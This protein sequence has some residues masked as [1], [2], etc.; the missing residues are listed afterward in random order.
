M[1]IHRR[2]FGTVLTMTRSRFMISSMDSRHQLLFSFL[3]ILK[4][5]HHFRK[6]WKE[7]QRMNRK[8]GKIVQEISSHKATHHLH[9]RIHS[10]KATYK[11]YNKGC[12]NPREVL[13]NKNLLPQNVTVTYLF[14]TY[15]PVR[16]SSEAM[17]E[18]KMLVFSYEA[19]L[20]DRTHT[21][22]SPAC[23]NI[24]EVKIIV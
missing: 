12:F 15:A 9:T 7:R 20:Y 22:Y 16:R 17:A 11:G 8:K 4:S 23:T 10:I 5:T 24:L 14:I 19:H 6:L 3:F 21:L 13:I 1:S 18:I 2:L